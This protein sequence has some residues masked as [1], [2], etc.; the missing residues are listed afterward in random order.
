MG[1]AM[2]DAQSAIQ[3]ASAAFSGQRRGL[4]CF[5]A[6]LAGGRSVRSARRPM[7]GQEHQKPRVCAMCEHARVFLVLKTVLKT[8]L[9]KKFLPENCL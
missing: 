4:S 5:A 2:I 9:R 1:L 6:G 3:E 7:D 8:V